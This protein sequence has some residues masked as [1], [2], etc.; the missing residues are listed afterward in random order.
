MRKNAVALCA[1]LVAFSIPL[2]RADLAAINPKALPQETA[3]LAALDDARQ[4]EPYSR[5][6]TTDSQWN[7]P[8][9]KEEVAAR[10]GK[11]LGFLQLALKKHPG[12]AELLLLTGLVVHYA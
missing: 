8:F 12:N 10:L 5:S 2:L 9:A 4:L 11:D 1:F 3:V 6:F 7:F